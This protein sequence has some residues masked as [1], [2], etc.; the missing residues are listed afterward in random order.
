MKK[1]LNVILVEKS[2]MSFVLEALKIK[3]IDPDKVGAI[4]KGKV[5]GSDLGSLLELIEDAPEL[6]KEDTKENI[7]E[8]SS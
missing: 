2:A 5:Y 6:F 1:L 4:R 3:G 8:P 7:D